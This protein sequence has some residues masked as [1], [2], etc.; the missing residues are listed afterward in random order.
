MFLDVFVLTFFKENNFFI[1]WKTKKGVIEA[2]FQ[3]YPDF[4]ISYVRYI[5]KYFPCNLLAIKNIIII[6]LIN[7]QKKKQANKVKV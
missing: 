2:Q 4:L 6:P 1:I 7:M 3:G 5:L